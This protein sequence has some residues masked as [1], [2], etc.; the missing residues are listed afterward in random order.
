LNDDIGICLLE[1]FD[2][3]LEWTRFAV[4]IPNR[5]RDFFFGGSCRLCRRLNRG[6]CRGRF[7]EWLSR[8]WLGS[9][10]SSRRQGGQGW[11]WCDARGYKESQD[12]EQAQGASSEHW[13]LLLTLSSLT[14][15]PHLVIRW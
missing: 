4:V 1:R 14:G 13:H 7:R 5:K 3:R 6:G 12:D 2:E 10:D 8:R 11:Q 9:W 15:N